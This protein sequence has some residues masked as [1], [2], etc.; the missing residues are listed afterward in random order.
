[1]TKYLNKDAVDCC[2][3]L[4]ITEVVTKTENGPAGHQ[5]IRGPLIDKIIL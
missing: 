3:S 5:G 4:P 2:S 1:M